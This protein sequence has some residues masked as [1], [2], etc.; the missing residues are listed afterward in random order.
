MERFRLLERIGSGGMG[1]VYR[2]FDERLQRQVAVKCLS[3]ADPDRVM[4]EAQAAARLNHPAIVTLYELGEHEGHAVLV[5]ELVPGETLAALETAG[6]LCD[7]DVGEL[8]A[9]LCEAL[10]HAHDR[11]VVHRDIK[12]ENIIVRELGGIGRRAKLMDFGIAR[13]SGAPTLTAHGEVVGT[14]AYMSPEQAEGEIA[15][16]PSDVYSLALT[17][18]ECWAGANP[19]AGA[20]P[21]ET[22]RRI[23]EPVAPLRLSRPDLPEGLADTIDACLDPDPQFRPS[24][25]E[26]RDCVLAE[27][28][29]LDDVQQLPASHESATHSPPRR[30]AA[31]RLA[32]LAASTILLALIA[33]P[34]AAPGLA[35]VLAVLALP[36]LLIGATVGSLAVCAAPLL[37]A[38]GLGPAAAGLGAPAPNAP[39][40]A[41]LGIGAW[42]WLFGGA[43]ALGIGPM[44]GL[45]PAAPNAWLGDASLAA[46]TI[47]RPLAGVDSIAAAAIFALASVALGRLLELRHAALALLA[48][49]LWAAAVNAALSVVGDGSLADRP[50]IVVATAGLAVAL[51]FGVLRGRAEGPE[52][53]TVHAQPTHEPRARLTGR[54][55]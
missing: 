19:V 30:I 46:E 24:P 53:G 42:A 4:R 55:A 33:G 41:V 29:E 47:L 17:A 13:L 34:L 12:P 51:E 54:L 23:G 49:M 14:L 5:S 3:A 10:I 16:P 28:P 18:Y 25:F 26:L 50:I 38:V 40:R 48:A 37:G 32:V 11:G 22:A 36:S 20:T 15:G 39:S 52:P 8:V 1:T 9:D 21:A 45:A 2:G 43:V 31:P 27:L 35:L 44:L 7:H 6:D